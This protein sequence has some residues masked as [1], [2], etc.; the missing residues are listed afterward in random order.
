MG[1]GEGTGRGCTRP[2]PKRDGQSEENGN[3]LINEP[4]SALNRAKACANEKTVGNIVLLNRGNRREVHLRRHG[5]KM[6]SRIK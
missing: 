1:W 3:I 2:I 6:K 5:E 4:A